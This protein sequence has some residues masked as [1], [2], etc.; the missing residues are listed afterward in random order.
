MRAQTSAEL[1]PATLRTRR[2]ATFALVVALGVAGWLPTSYFMSLIV[3]EQLGGGI[4][5][6]ALVIGTLHLTRI[7]GSLATGHWIARLSSRT[8][9][10]LGLAGM[11]VLMLTLVLAPNVGWVIAVAPLTGLSMACFW[12]GLQTYQ[13][14]TAPPPRRGAAVGI[15]GFVVVLVPGVA[16]VGQGIVADAF[17]FRVFALVAGAALVLSLL[18]TL[19]IL[20]G[21]SAPRAVRRSP[22]IGFAELVRFRSLG[23][24]LA[25]RTASSIG[26][27]AVLLLAGPK[28]IAAGGDLRTV[29]AMTL[30]AAIGGA[31]AQVAI[32][33]WSDHYG[34]R[35]AVVLALALAIPATAA[36][37]FVDNIAGLLI[38]AT[39][40][41][42]ANWGINTMAV[43]LCGD[44]APPGALSRVM[45][46]DGVAFS[47]GTTAGAILIAATGA[48]VPQ[49]GFYVGATA[50]VLGLTAVPLLGRTIRS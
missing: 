42:A 27:A 8:V 49:I 3:R 14:E 41:A 26:Y 38:V 47:M 19:R 33:R 21:P 20:P 36:F 10:S 18:L 2:F 45:V 50:L 30:V 37:G 44:L 4:T 43:T 12:T 7:V 25:I 46:L 32:G 22:S 34:R 23:A 9:H 28:M 16:G 1:H 40:W 13:I 24:V 17:G 11:V 35:L 15:I 29:G 6:A 39:V 31:A 48:A 5:G